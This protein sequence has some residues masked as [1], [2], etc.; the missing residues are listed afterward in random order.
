M[1]YKKH[2]RTYLLLI[3]IKRYLTGAITVLFMIFMNWARSGKKIPLRRRAELLKCF[4]E[5]RC[6]EC[7]SE[8]RVNKIGYKYFFETFMLLRIYFFFD[9]V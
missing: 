1:H 2:M 8:F 4:N 7:M 6:Y 5:L 3:I 9:T